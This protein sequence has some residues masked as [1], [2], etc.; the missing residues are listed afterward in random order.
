MCLLPEN[1]AHLRGEGTASESEREERKT[2]PRGRT[3]NR[4]RAGEE[5]E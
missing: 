3:D 4:G 1:T 5:K 2:E